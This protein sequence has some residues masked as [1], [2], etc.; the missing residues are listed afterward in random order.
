MKLRR[1]KIMDEKTT[2]KILDEHIEDYGDLLRACEEIEEVV[3][4]TENIEAEAEEYVY[5]T[6]T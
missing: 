5:F 3:T 2:F 1:G 4:D 6:Q